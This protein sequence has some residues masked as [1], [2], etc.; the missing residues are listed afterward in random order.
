MRRPQRAGHRRA[1]LDLDVSQYPHAE[2]LIEPAE[3]VGYR[4][5]AL[6]AIEQVV[7]LDLTVTA[8]YGAFRVSENIEYAPDLMH[9]AKLLYADSFPSTFFADTDVLNIVV[10]HV[11]F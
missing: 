5:A 10:L 11:L 8:A 7:R 2:V 4:A 3:F 6:R 1:R 9:S